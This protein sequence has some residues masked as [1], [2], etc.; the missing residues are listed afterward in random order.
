MKKERFKLVPAVSLLLKRDNK[1]LLQRRCNTGWCDDCYALVGGGIEEGETAFTAVI[2]E[3]EEEIGITLQK[4]D[5]RIVH[6]LHFR[7]V[8][9]SEG[10]TFFLE[11]TKWQGDPYI[12]EPAKSADMDWFAIDD[13]PKNIVVFLPSLLVK[14]NQGILYSEYGWD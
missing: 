12:C 6:V 2:R 9:G 3:A 4:H 11:A 7:N 8:Q 1:I 10:I 13:L 14:M 5:L